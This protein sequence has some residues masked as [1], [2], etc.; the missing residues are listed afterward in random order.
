MGHGCTVFSLQTRVL[1]RL[2]VRG[3]CFVPG[4][5]WYEWCWLALAAANVALL[6]PFTLLQ[7]FA[8]S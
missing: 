4:S 2:T 3:E 5:C 8:C 6:Q 7:T 1:Q